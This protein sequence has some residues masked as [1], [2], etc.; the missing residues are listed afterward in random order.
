[1]TELDLSGPDLRS[2]KKRE[3]VWMQRGRNG[4]YHGDKQLMQHLGC[5]FDL[6]FEGE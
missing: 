1:M 2:T 3:I 5:E 6:A 4:S